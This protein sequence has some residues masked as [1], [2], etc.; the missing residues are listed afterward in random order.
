MTEQC[1]E[2]GNDVNPFDTGVMEIK[3]RAAPRDERK[4][5]LCGRCS[6]RLVS[7]LRFT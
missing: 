6:D 2:C 3:Y 7:G 4:Y 1:A 5:Y